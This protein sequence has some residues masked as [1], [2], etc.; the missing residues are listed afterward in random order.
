MIVFISLYSKSSPGL[1]YTFHVSGGRLC[2]H[3]RRCGVLPADR[4]NGSPVLP[5]LCFRIR[6]GIFRRIVCEAGTN[7]RQLQRNKSYGTFAKKGFPKS[8][9]CEYRKVFYISPNR[10]FER[11]ILHMMPFMALS[12]RYQMAVWGKSSVIS[13]PPGLHFP[14]A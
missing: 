5:F 6:F 4:F 3:I 8:A 10:S 9:I 2:H 13:H 1:S 11:V 14:S 7:V 12:V